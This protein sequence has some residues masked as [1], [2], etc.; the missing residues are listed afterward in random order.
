MPTIPNAESTK[1]KYDLTMRIHAAYIASLIASHEDKHFVLDM[2]LIRADQVQTDSLQKDERV[3]PVCTRE[4]TDSLIA[5]EHNPG[6]FS[7]PFALN[8]TA[9]Q[10]ENKHVVCR[11]CLWK[12]ASDSRREGKEFACPLCRCVF[13]LVTRFREHEVDL[14]PVRLWEEGYQEWERPIDL[15]DLI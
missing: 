7:Q 5:I 2:P 11:S 9:T 8:C 10:G 13:P 6:E 4:F 15:I 14:I 3:R 12:L 1:R